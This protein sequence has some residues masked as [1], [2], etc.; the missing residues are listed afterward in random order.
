MD[1][2]GA[3]VAGGRA[4]IVDQGYALTLGSAD[5]PLTADA[6]GRIALEEPIGDDRIVL[7]WAPGRAAARREIE[8]APQGVVRIALGAP[9]ELRGRVSERESTMQH[10]WLQSDEAGAPWPYFVRCDVDGEGRFRANGVAAGT[11]HVTAVPMGMAPVLAADTAGAV[12][13]LAAEPGQVGA[14]SA[15]FIDRTIAA[16][17]RE[18][19]LRVAYGAA[20][21]RGSVVD[22]SGAP[23]PD[24][25]VRILGE[26]GGEAT[27]RAD[28]RGQFAV[29]VQPS[30]N[31]HISA[32][33]EAFGLQWTDMG[34]ERWMVGGPIP[35][36]PVELVLRR[37]VVVAGRLLD[38]AGRPAGHRTLLL[39]PAYEGSGPRPLEARTDA[40][41]RFAFERAV[42]DRFEI[43]PGGLD[44][45]HPQEPGRYVRVAEPSTE[46]WLAAARRGGSIDLEL[47]SYEIVPVTADVSA[48]RD[49][50]IVEVWTRW[51]PELYRGTT[52]N[53]VHGHVTVPMERG[54][55]HEL[56]IRSHASGQSLEAPWSHGVAPDW[57]GTP[58][59]STR[60]TIRPRT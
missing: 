23:V 46:R 18:H 5:A 20:V 10:V 34:W 41:G 37:G 50:P 26:T 39:I 27:A 56:W 57:T 33:H 21:V 8:G 11:Y 47:A 19:V 28:A 7:A 15:R 36:A 55:P 42:L 4:V 52:A 60:V 30:P 32:R 22:E 35:D 24:A 16:D 45:W 14:A 40:Q 53:V 9:S 51:G 38:E 3:P 43:V 1:E 25:A 12:R 31:V 13:L 29:D 2:A 49:Q 6:S 54:V 17:G 48:I 58:D 59:G 44:D